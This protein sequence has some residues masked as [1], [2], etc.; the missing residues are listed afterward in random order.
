[1]RLGKRQLLTQCSAAHPCKGLLAESIATAMAS[2]V[3]ILGCVHPAG[4][5][6]RANAHPANKK[7]RRWRAQ[8]NADGPKPAQRLASEAL[9]QHDARDCS[10]SLDTTHKRARRT[11]KDSA[12]P[13]LRAAAADAEAAPKAVDDLLRVTTGL[14]EGRSMKIVSAKPCA[15]TARGKRA[16]FVK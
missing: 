12:Y 11:N 2:S 8:A 7:K 10:R 14:R 3:P 5:H 1:M 15:G 9:P 6:R 16:L 4:T 13:A